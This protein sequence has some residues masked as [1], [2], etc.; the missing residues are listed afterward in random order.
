MYHR[1]D[2]TQFN[3]IAGYGWRIGRFPLSMQLNVSNL[4]NRYNV[5]VMLNPTT[6]FNGPLIATID[7]QPRAYML[8]STI[9]F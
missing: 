9:S 6:G 4:L 2:M 3:L 7:S 1:P 5:L 8:T